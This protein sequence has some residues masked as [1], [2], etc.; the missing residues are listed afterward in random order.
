MSRKFLF[1]ILLVVI[2]LV[3]LGIALGFRQTAQLLPAGQGLPDLEIVFIPQDSINT[4][5]FI[6]SDGSGYATRTI[7]MSDSFWRDLA[8][9]S[10]PLLTDWFTWSPDGQYL[11]SSVSRQDRVSLV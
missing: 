1:P 8:R 5:G 3:I 4:L 11:V 9:M 6:D 2:I 7:K 10:K